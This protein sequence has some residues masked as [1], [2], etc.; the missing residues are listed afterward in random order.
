MSFDNGLDGSIAEDCFFSMV[1]FQ[2]STERLAPV[3]YRNCL[4]TSYRF[5]IFY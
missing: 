3:S 5:G 4:T 2:V 1:A